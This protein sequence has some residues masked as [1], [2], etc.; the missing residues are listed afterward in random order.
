MPLIKVKKFTENCQLGVWRIEETPETLINLAIL[1]SWEEKKFKEFKTVLRKSHWLSVRALLNEIEKQKTE[2]FYTEKGRPFLKNGLNISIS[3]SGDIAG[4]ITGQTKVGIDI[5]EISDKVD[6]VKNKFLS[7][8]ELDF[9]LKQ[10]DSLIALTIAWCVKESVFKFHSESGLIFK[11]H[12][13]IS[14]FEVNTSGQIE[15]LLC[16]EES[17]RLLVH[18]EK[19]NN[20]IIAYLRE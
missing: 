17:R 12:I 11:D 2:I 5:E 8:N 9:I 16:K 4:I 1:T 6:R 18:Y 15:T 19:I 13:Q 3:H 7:T 20:H 14:P 10:P